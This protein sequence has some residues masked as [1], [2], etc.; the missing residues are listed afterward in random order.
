[1]K[2]KFY[3]AG[4]RRHVREK[5]AWNRVE[6]LTLWTWK[7]LPGPKDRDRGSYNAYEI[8]SLVLQPFVESMSD[9][10][11][12]QNILNLVEVWYPSIEG[13]GEDIYITS[14]KDPDDAV[15][16]L[17]KLLVAAEKKHLF[18]WVPTGEYIALRSEYNLS[19]AEKLLYLR[20]YTVLRK[21]FSKFGVPYAEDIL[22]EL[23]QHWRLEETEQEKE[24]IAELQT[25]VERI[26]L[27][28]L[29][30]G[31]Q[32]SIWLYS[33]DNEKNI[34]HGQYEGDHI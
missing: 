7:K 1:M 33:K 16:L 23:G 22:A 10:E 6:G 29:V 15:H 12:Q 17:E 32:P 34:I 21:K 27:M 30:Q 20:G 25:F 26:G 14:T 31:K 13:E 11:V 2:G 4:Q 9:E 24:M 18:D 28:A 8:E 5:D 3:E 19:P